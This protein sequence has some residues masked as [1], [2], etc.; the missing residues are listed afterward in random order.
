MNGQ[1]RFSSVL[2]GGLV[3]PS[4]LGTAMLTAAAYRGVP[5]DELGRLIVDVDQHPAAR[6][7]DQSILHQLAHHPE[8][9]M[10]LQRIAL[11]RSVLF[12]VDA[13][14]RAAIRLLAIM[15]PGDLM[16]NTPL[17]F[18]TTHLDVQLDIL[19]LMPGR[20]L[21]AVLPDHDIAFMA[22]SEADP[23]MLLR[24]RHLCAMWPRP[25]LNHPVALP[26]L[27]RTRLPAVLADI[28]GLYCPPAVAVSLSHLRAMA[29][30][31]RVLHDLLPSAT[32]PILVRPAGSHAGAG[33]VRLD[34]AAA[35]AR[36]LPHAPATACV[37]PF[38]DYRS[39]DSWYRKYRV[40]FIDRTPYLCHLAISAHWMVH[41]LNAGMTDCA[42]KR[43]MEAEAMAGFEAGFAHRH[44]AGFAALCSRLDLDVFSIDCGEL[45]DGRLVVFEADT[46]AIIHA[47]DA[48]DVFPYKPAQMRRVFSA[49]GDLLHRRVGPAT[50]LS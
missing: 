49:F 31:P 23:A 8:D 44:Q 24:L 41:Y 10:G 39:A 29:Q 34:D 4:V 19:F 28:P 45:P 33:L 46:A 16:V 17:D 50:S 5:L 18:I 27:A 7:F 32:F 47:M 14:R 20:P 12:R 21:P 13:G 3:P 36:H 26:A 37:T 48:P 6:S 9:A 40:M 35:L 43:A 11:D 30:D 2:S 38:V 42:A 15:A 25:V 22:I 1:T